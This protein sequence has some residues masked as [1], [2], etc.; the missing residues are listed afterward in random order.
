MSIPLLD[1]QAQYSSIKDEVESAVLDVLRSGRYILGP[2]VKEFEAAIADYCGA[3]YA[4]GVANGTDALVLSLEASGIGPGDEVITSPFTFFATAES[5]SRLGAKPVFID[6]DPQ[7]YNLDVEQIEAK[8]TARTKAI[9][10]V[11]IFGQPAE[12]DTIDDIA[13]R[14]GIKVI[15]DACQAIG[16][17]YRG[18]KVGSLGSVACFSF[19]PS[20]NLGAAG[21]GGAV[22]TNDKELA[23]KVRLLRQHGSNKKY[24]HSLMGYNSRLD[25]L[26]AAILLVK[27]KHIDRWNNA[28]RQKAKYYDKLFADT[29]IITPSSPEHVKHVYHLYIIKVPNR[30]RIETALKENGIGHGVYYPVPLHLQEVYKDLGYTEG[31]LPVS[32]AASK[33]TI[34]IPLYPELEESDMEIIAD[35]IKRAVDF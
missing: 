18:R 16:A 29:K 8:I 28:R 25:E 33:Q 12:M 30:E 5:I 31:D 21:D 22:V 26:Q 3:K 2:K 6:I 32:E 7:T 35:I 4:V 1:L 20:K 15:E 23:D 13:Q 9:M 14:H 17:E 24:H 34:A 10:P 19:F 11:H 27:L